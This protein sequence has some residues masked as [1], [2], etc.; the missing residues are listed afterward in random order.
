MILTPFIQRREH[1]HGQGTLS[2]TQFNG[3]LTEAVYPQAA[4]DPIR[5]GDT[6]A[7]LSRRPVAFMQLNIAEWG[8][9]I[10]PDFLADNP[11]PLLRRPVGN[12]SNYQLNARAQNPV[13]IRP[14]VYRPPA[15]AYGSLFS[16]S[17]PTYDLT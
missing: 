4:P 9:G 6:P 5:Q 13:G 3:V 1:L 7:R 8:M 11:H 12:V 2:Y 15:I 10:A 14:N 16:L 17:A